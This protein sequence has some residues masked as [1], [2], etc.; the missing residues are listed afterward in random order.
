MADHA[1]PEIG[2]AVERRQLGDAFQ[3]DDLDED[4]RRLEGHAAQPARHFCRR[5]T[6]ELRQLAVGIQEGLLDN[7][8]R[9]ELGAQ[10]APD[11]HPR[12]QQEIAPKLFHGQ[13][14]VSGWLVHGPS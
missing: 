11:L 1:P 10:L 13:F 3:A 2:L 6:A 7:V 8:R 9:I 12:Q 5:R 14:L 4:V